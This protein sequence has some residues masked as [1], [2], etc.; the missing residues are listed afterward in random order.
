MS[1]TADKEDGHMHGKNARV[2]MC[3]ATKKEHIHVLML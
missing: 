3:A 2:G 1:V